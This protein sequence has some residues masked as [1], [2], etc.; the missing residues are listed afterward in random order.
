MEGEEERTGRGGQGKGE[1]KDY[2]DATLLAL[3]MEEGALHQGIW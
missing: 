1:G 2:K 3:K